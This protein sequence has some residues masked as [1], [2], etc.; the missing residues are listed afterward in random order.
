MSTSIQPRDEVFPGYTLAER[1]GSGGYAEV[2]RATAPGGIN[3]AVKIVYGCHDDQLAAQEMKA[4]ERIRDVRHPFVVS[5]ERFE[6]VDGRLV[7]LTELADMSLE[8]RAQQCRAQGLPGIPREL[9]LRY[10]SDA[11][12][13]LDFL[14]QRHSLQHLDIKPAN[15]L[16][17]GDHVKVADF[18]LVKEL[19]TRT[20]NSMVAGM[21][22]TY[23]APE[24][25]DDAP[26]PHSDQYSLA[27]VYQEMLTGVLPFPGRTAA[28]LANQHLR[29]QPQLAA[30]PEADRPILARALAKNPSERFPSCRDL[31]KALSAN[32][33][34]T[35]T[36]PAPKNAAPSALGVPNDSNPKPDATIPRAAVP[37][38]HPSESSNVTDRATQPTDYQP[39]RTIDTDVNRTIAVEV[40]PPPE[41]VVDV[42]VPE[43]AGDCET[44]LPTLYIAIGG[45]GT[46]ILSHFR[47]LCAPQADSTQQA[48]PV[49]LM[50]IDTDRQE[51]K[52]AC[53]T[54]WK[55]PLSSNDTICTSLRLPQ[56]YRDRTQLNLDWLSHRWL[57]NI[58]R[59]LETRGYRPL[60]RLALVDHLDEVLALV[61][62]KLA[63]LTA[64][65]SVRIPPIGGN[66]PTEATTPIDLIRVVLL[67]GMGG[68]TGGGMAI[69]VANAVR[70]RIHKSGRRGQIECVLVCTCVGNASATPLS[71]ANTYALLRELQVASAFGNCGPRGETKDLRPFES[72]DRPFDI[73]YCVRAK[74]HAE[75]SVDEGLRAVAEQLAI[76]STDCVRQVL[77]SCRQSPTD[78]ESAGRDSLRLRTFGASSL[79]GRER[80]RIE[81]LAKKSARLVEEYWLG[82]VG[83]TDWK[84]LESEA[85]AAI[86]PTDSAVNSTPADDDAPI[87]AAV[88]SRVQI[89]EWRHQFGE[90]GSTRFAYGVV[91][92]IARQSALRG[93][94]R[95]TLLSSQDPKKFV[96][97]AS[98]ALSS[99]CD[100]IAAAPKDCDPLA[101]EDAAIVDKLLL[102]SHRILASCI[103]E[104]ERLP[105][106]RSLDAAKIDRVVKNECLVG[107]EQCVVRQ[108]A[109]KGEKSAVS[110]ESEAQEALDGANVD[111]LQCGYDRRTLI[112]VPYRAKANPK[113]SEAIDAVAKARTTATLI[114]A[115]VDEPVVYCEGSGLS[116][117]SFARGLERVYP[118]IAE[119]A[120]R[121]HTRSD[122]D[123]STWPA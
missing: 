61:D 22:P 48:A 64:V 53:S 2:W 114:V 82:D 21:T 80:K 39:Q 98:E 55:Y 87:A 65:Q 105:A 119:A 51:L 59:S 31:V 62:R 73:V 57:Y 69:D 49:E 25:F 60:G 104:I 99:I 78:K 101:V 12:D 34:T 122:I 81:R 83:Q 33:K 63:A 52:D 16:I 103:D 27:I 94:Y 123:W 89:E 102:N 121:R 75:G 77:D 5:L 79:T 20:H 86:P 92:R 46:R 40:Q 1:I 42:P 117:K 38:A 110:P 116:P 85:E 13:A 72:A 19:A 93:A 43:V 7:I 23:S 109:G 6:V 8:Q 30:L 71:V 74:Q 28:Q 84:Q 11:A 115:E 36:R 17:L 18:G 107:V 113:S 3:K 112:V 41:P 45:V 90:G 15:L 44:T 26:S 66:Q 96:S 91:S 108:S 54:K 35:A 29:S 56:E 67:V 14:A 4:M 118:G 106:D 111:L 70:S 58:P 88:I 120:S 50:A 95:L 100:R 32:G 37:A 24:M 97:A 68:G 10:L 76:A 9:L 47:D